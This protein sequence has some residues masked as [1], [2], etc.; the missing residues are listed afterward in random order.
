MYIQ[1]INYYNVYS[2]IINYCNKT[3]RYYNHI[4]IPDSQMQRKQILKVSTNFVDRMY[5]K[6]NRIC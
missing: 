6:Y 5:Q 3:L 4:T 2:L 1:D